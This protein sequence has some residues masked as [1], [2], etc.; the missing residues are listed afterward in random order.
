[1]KIFW[2]H[3]SNANGFSIQKLA[4]D[5][6]LKISSESADDVSNQN[7]ENNK[8]KIIPNNANNISVVNL[9]LKRIHWANRD[10]SEYKKAA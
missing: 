2:P 3:R 7:L 9:S 4:R 10:F 5:Y 8:S 1:L 6:R